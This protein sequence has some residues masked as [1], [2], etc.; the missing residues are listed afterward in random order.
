M[1][2]I[3]FLTAGPEIVASSRTRVYQFV[4]YLEKAGFKCR[5][6]NYESER[7]CRGNLNR[8]KKN[9]I[10]KIAGKLY[11]FLQVL[12][13]IISA[14][15]YDILFIQRVLIPIGVQRFIKK[16]NSNIFFDFDDALYLNPEKKFVRRLDHLIR[17]SRAVFLENRFTK[18]YASRLNGN[19]FTITGPIEINKYIPRSDGGN[20][21]R[22]VIGWIGS[23][24]TA[25]FV[26]TLKSVFKK[27]SDRY[28]K[29]EI[30]L[31]G[32]PRLELGIN[33]IY[34]KPWRP[35]TEVRDLQDFDIGIMPLLDDDWSRG[36]GGYKLLQYMSIGIP[37][38]ASAVG[39]NKE[40]L[41]D[42]FNGFLAS[43]D[44]EWFEKLSSLIEDP[45]LRKRMGKEARKIAVE[46]Y[47]YEASCP[48]LSGALNGGLS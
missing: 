48:T 30:H 32:A 45:G 38:V 13:F 12:R 29:V 33:N 22:V 1:K 35:D 24:A 21:E 23:F 15:K 39:I 34:I 41:K 27:L 5:I 6:I 2:K 37:S 40:I 46:R 36:K 18:D 11:S 20:R 4:P 28:P 10:S 44:R 25:E 7:S 43:D 16:T 19:I 26:K 47:S 3:L 31:I 8:V 14:P 9:I 17:E 42:G